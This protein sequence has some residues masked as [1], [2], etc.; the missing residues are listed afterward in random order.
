MGRIRFDPWFMARALVVAAQVAHED[1]SITDVVLF[2]GHYD[3]VDAYFVGHATDHWTAMAWDNRDTDV[4]QNRLEVD[5]PGRCLHVYVEHVASL[6]EM[7]GD[8]RAHGM[9]LSM[10]DFDEFVPWAEA[11]WAAS[12]EVRKGTIEEG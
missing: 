11:E 9:H 4:I 2:R 8:P 1:P 6:A 12:H 10:A 7:H 3:D 5:C